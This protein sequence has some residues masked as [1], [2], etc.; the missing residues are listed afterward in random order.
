LRIAAHPR[1]YD[2]LSEPPMLNGAQCAACG[3]VSFPPVLLGCE[4]CGATGDELAPTALAAAGQVHSLAEVYVHP[5]AAEL[6]FTVAEIVL[7]AGPLIR[8]ML[9][10]QSDSVQI[11]DRVVGAWQVTGID[12]SGSAVVEPVF[13]AEM[14]SNTAGP[15]SDSP[16]G[17]QR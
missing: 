2:A 3:H 13:V 7:D 4:I 16:T 12:G 5:S 9:D 8:A 15:S 1:L 14:A 17:G 6:P 11:G 10:P